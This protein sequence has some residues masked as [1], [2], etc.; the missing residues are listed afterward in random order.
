MFHGTFCLSAVARVKSSPFGY[1]LQQYND[2]FYLA[3]V[4]VK[5]DMPIR[6]ENET[7]I[8]VSNAY[9]ILYKSLSNKL[10]SFISIYFIKSAFKYPKNKAGFFVCSL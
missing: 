3:K 6:P 7:E 4:R 9:F 2:H 8:E 10:L 1:V 5:Q